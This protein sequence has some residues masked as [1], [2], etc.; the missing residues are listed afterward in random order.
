MANPAT[1]LDVRT[2]QGI[3]GT[4]L[5]TAGAGG[6]VAANS[7]TIVFLDRLGS[8]TN[9][10]IAQTTADSNFFNGAVDAGEIFTLF[11]FSIQ[12]K[13]VTNV[14]GP[15]VPAVAVVQEALRNLSFTLNLKGQTYPIG[16]LMT[17]PSPLGSEQMVK[18]GGNG[19]APFRFPRAIPL[20]IG[21]LDQYSVTVKAERAIN[22]SGG[23]NTIGVF[24]YCPASRGIPLGQ[25]S[26]A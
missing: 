14:G 1:T 21:S 22:T 20:Q 26:G 2:L 23:T 7:Q 18:N 19:V 8:A 5:L 15:V 25:L 16:S 13:E 4:G 11:G 17:V 12:I 3:Y 10:N 9:S 6:V 24:I